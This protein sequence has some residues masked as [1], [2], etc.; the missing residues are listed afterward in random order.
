MKP[1]FLSHSRLE[2]HKTGNFLRDVILGG[3]DGLVNVLGIV[4]GISAAGGDT[5]ILFA[6]A[7]AATFSEALSM[8]AVAYTSTL[9]EQDHYLREL[10]IEENEIRDLPDLEREEFERFIKPRDSLE[11]YL[12]ASSPPFLPTKR[13]GSSL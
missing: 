6:A 1:T 2:S 8:G 11:T 9:T 3:Q 13:I 12:K 7:L 4:L 10:Q 5:K